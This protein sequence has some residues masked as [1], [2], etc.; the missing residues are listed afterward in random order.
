MS[1]SEI[2]A[3]DDG[4]YLY[5]GADGSNSVVR[6]DL[7]TQSVDIT[8]SL[9]GNHTRDLHILPGQPEAIAVAKNNWGGVEIYDKGVRRPRGDQW[10]NQIE[11]N[12]DGTMLFG[13]SSDVSSYDIKQYNISANGLQFVGATDYLVGG[14]DFEWADDKLFFD[15]GQ[16]LDALT[17]TLIGSFSRPFASEVIPLPGTNRVAYISDEADTIQVFNVTTQQRIANIQVPGWPWAHRG[18]AFGDD[19]IAFVD[20]DEKVYIVRSDL[21]SGVTRH[22]IM[23]N[24]SDPE[25]D[26]LTLALVETTQHGTLDLHVDGTFTY[27][28]DP[29]FLWRRFVHLHGQR[30]PVRLQHGHRQD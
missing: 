26:P 11:V 14:G 18:I 19:G 21:I 10:N 29:E 8:F 1:V 9:G 15:S 4:Q 17:L 20:D 7:A 2:V 6:I 28:P 24:D 22:D 16:M 12:G 27:E 30:W 3:T 23:A 13:F 25:D 5:V